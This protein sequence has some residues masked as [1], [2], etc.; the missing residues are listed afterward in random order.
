MHIAILGTR[1]IPAHYG[2]FETNAEISA[3]FLARHGHQVTVYSRQKSARPT[4][5]PAKLKIIYIPYLSGKYL[6]TLS[7]TFFSLCHTLINRPDILHL[8]NVG[9]GPLLI[10]TK[11]FK[12]KTLISIDG[13]DWDRKKYPWPARLYIRFSAWCAVKLADVLIADSQHI[14]NYYWRQYRVKTTFLPYGGE[15]LKR[16]PQTDIF[17]KYHLKPKNYCLFVSRFVPEKNIPLLI[18]AYKKSF[19]KYPLV[20]V[21]TNPDDREYVKKL[22]RLGRGEK[23]IFPGAIYDSNLDALYKQAYAFISASELEGTSPAILKALGT[24]TAVLVSDIAEN[25]ETVGSAGFYHRVYDAEDLTD[26]INWLAQNPK[27]VEIFGNK[28]QNRVKEH[29]HWPDIM[30]R[31]L[32]LLRKTLAK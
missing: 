15:I 14:V 25:R 19:I 4:N 26:K 10:L 30:K 1:G 29:Y 27:M 31:Y 3:L 6:G 18:E 24:G 16:A 11:L 21:G 23:I 7:H 17:K 20:I 9:N 5:W 32:E 8:Y 13:A 22:R 28:G 2:G 12:I